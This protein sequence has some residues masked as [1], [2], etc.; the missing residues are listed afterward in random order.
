MR[1]D[2]RSAHEAFKQAVQ[3]DGAYA[4]ARLERGL[5]FIKSQAFNEGIRE[6]KRY[7]ELV[8]PSLPD[9]RVDAV[10]K[11]IEQ[12]EE[13]EGRQAPRGRGVRAARRGA[14]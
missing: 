1:G 4:P 9:A 7:T 3:A 8:D 11:L 5:L 13:S 6:L 10:E 14:S 12:L 2:D